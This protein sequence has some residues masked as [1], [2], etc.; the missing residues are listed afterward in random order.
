M[1]IERI[2]P[3]ITAAIILLIPLS[4]AAQGFLLENIPFGRATLGVRFMHPTLTEDSSATFLSGVYEFSVGIPL[5]RR[6]NLIATMP[7]ATLRQDR[8]KGD[9]SVGNVF[10]GF[11]YRLR[12]S[13]SN[14]SALSFG[15]LLP[16][17]SSKRF[18]SNAMGQLTHFYKFIQFLPDTWG[19]RANFSYHHSAREG[20]LYGFEI[21]PD[22]EIP[23]NK[24]SLRDTEYY[25]HY[26][27]TAG[28][29]FR[30]VSFKAEFLGIA[31]LSEDV[32]KFSDRV[33]QSLVIGIRW[34]RRFLRPGIFYKLE[35][36]KELRDEISS[37]FGISLDL[38]LR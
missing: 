21:G 34:E 13:R 37:V 18:A 1:K 27:L 30:S 22:I 23:T 15:V 24:D 38:A 17:A 20:L 12:R 33:I 36:K 11:Q 3:V 4:A 7:F 29:R 32:D 31:L 35:L 26:G 8:G 6:V 2:K 25:I 9:S 10:A 19:I 14:R 16:T 28:Y 5:Y